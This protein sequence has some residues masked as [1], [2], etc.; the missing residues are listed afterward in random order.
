MSIDL[1]SVQPHS[2]LLNRRKCHWPGSK[3]VHEADVRNLTHSKH[4]LCGGAPTSTKEKESLG[5]MSRR[6]R[7]DFLGRDLGRREECMS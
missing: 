1:L 4:Q 7:E 6:H 2:E 3:E 5:F